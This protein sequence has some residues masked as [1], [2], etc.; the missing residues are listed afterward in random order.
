MKTTHANDYEVNPDFLPPEELWEM[1]KQLL[2]PA[3]ARPKGGRPPMSD[4]TAFYAIYYLLRTGMQ[5]KALPRSLGAASTVHRRFQKWVLTGIFL[6][7]WRWCLYN[8]DLMHGLDWEWQALD[9]AM[10]KAP[11]GCENTGP[12][13][14]DR[15]KRGTKRHVLTEGHGIPLAVVVTGANRN[16]FKETRRVLEQIVIARPK[17]T[18]RKQQ[19]LCLDK[20]Y[21]FPE[22]D[23]IV[24]DFGYTAHISRRGQKTSKPQSLPT[25]RSRRW[26]VERTHSWMNRFRRILI[27]WEKKTENY[28]AFLHLTCAYITIRAAGVLG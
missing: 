1:V 13:P 26:V 3:P 2:P 20:G 10:T 27:R 4:K 7:L 11:L 5:W 19:H 28:E 9:G 8:Y 22:V 21:D 12:N 15:A 16:D 24:A 6:D 25:Y 18:A 23:E 14:T 17:P